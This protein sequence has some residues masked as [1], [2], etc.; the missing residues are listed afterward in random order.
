MSFSDIN[1]LSIL[2]YDVSKTEA[3][4]LNPTTSHPGNLKLY[5]AFPRV[6]SKTSAKAEADQMN[7]CRDKS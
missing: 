6:P 3:D 4:A 1:D 2:P 7:R 5:N